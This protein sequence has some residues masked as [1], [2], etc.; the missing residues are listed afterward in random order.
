MVPYIESYQG[1]KVKYYNHNRF[2]I[3]SAGRDKQFGTGGYLNN[4]SSTAEQ[5]AFVNYR[6]IVEEN[7]PQIDERQANYDNITNINFSRVVPR[8]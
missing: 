6:Y 5:S 8:P 4:N 7:I 1:G 2:Q 3:I